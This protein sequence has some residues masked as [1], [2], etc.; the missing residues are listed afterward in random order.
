[1]RSEL[2]VRYPNYNFA[3][4]R[5]ISTISTRVSLSNY[6]CTGSHI[7]SLKQLNR[8]SPYDVFNRGS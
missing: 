4:L 5:F 3:F 7:E 8:V 6:V 2:C 1:M